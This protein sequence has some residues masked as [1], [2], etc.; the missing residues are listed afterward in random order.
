MLKEDP[1]VINFQRKQTFL[2]LLSKDSLSLYTIMPGN[3]KQL[4]KCVK[5]TI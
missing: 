3:N 2:S 5:T 1:E 4:R